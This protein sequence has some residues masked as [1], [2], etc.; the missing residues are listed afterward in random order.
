MCMWSFVLRRAAKS[1]RIHA[2][3]SFFL[4]FLGNVAESDA[5]VSDRITASVQFAESNVAIVVTD[6]NPE[7][8]K[9]PSA[10]SMRIPNST[11]FTRGTNDCDTTT[12]VVA[13]SRDVFTGLLKK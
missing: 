11:A 4:I 2:F 5:A 12:A 13:G 8:L 10:N 1:R 3:A 7:T 6:W 9:I